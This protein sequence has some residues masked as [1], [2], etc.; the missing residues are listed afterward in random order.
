MKVLFV[1][2]TTA[3]LVVVLVEDNSIKDFSRKNCGTHHSETLC[4][5]VGN[6]LRECG[7]RFA[8]LDAYACAVGPGSFTGIRIGI[9]TVKGYVSAVPKPIVALNCLKMISLSE[10]CGKKQ[11]AVINAGNGNYFADYVENVA[12]CLISYDDERATDAGRCGSATDYIDGA[13]ELIRKRFSQ[14]KFAKEL[15]PLY[16]RRSQ[17]EENKQWKN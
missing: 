12:P 14:K 1:D 16:I 15:E 7:L 13:V 2:T 17:A 6:A 4:D 11:C 10:N 5:C 9:S 3:D 8:D